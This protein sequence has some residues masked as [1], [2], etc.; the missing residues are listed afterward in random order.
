MK[1]FIAVLLCFAAIFAFAAC[2]K[3][4]PDTTTEPTGRPGDMVTNDNGDVVTVTD[5]ALIL[6]ENGEPQL[7]SDGNVMTTVGYAVATYP[8]A[9]GETLPPKETSPTVAPGNTIKSENAKWPADEFMSKLPKIKEI[10][11]VKTNITKRKIE[12]LIS[13]SP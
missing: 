4:E 9:E 3:N 13:L 10:R 8:P 6:D 11:A 12:G 2:T 5:F 7:D 1:K